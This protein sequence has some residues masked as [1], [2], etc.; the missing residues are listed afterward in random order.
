MSSRFVLI[1]EPFGNPA[2]QGVD[3]GDAKMGLDEVS[4][5]VL[6]SAMEKEPGQFG[7]VSGLTAA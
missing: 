6:Q 4:K 5:A 1:L 7:W 2:V 3:E